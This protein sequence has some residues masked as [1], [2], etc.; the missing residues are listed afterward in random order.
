MK[1]TVKT[2]DGEKNAAQAEI[3]AAKAS[4]L[5]KPNGLVN[6]I[7]M[8]YGFTCMFIMY[9]AQQYTKAFGMTNCGLM[10][11]AG[12]RHDIHLYS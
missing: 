1:E 5:V 9:G 2:A 4:M 8:F 7:T 3:D 12:G 10:E 11:N 6:F